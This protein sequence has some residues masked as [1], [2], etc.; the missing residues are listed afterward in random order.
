MVV[1]RIWRNMPKLYCI[2]MS[3]LFFP[4]DF[5][6]AIIKYYTSYLILHICIWKKPAVE[7]LKEIESFLSTNKEEVVTLFLEDYV[8]TSD[9]LKKVFNASGLMK[10]WFPVSKMPKDGG[11]WPSVKEMIDNNERLVVF[12]S[13]KSK[14]K[15][16]GIAYQWNYM[17]ETK[18]KKQSI[19]QTK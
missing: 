10:Y 11:N 7:T 9:A 14:E 13:N 18:C 1:S 15:Q 17:V 16:E 12:S 6:L 3:I 19:N 2:C 4:V 8:K 5:R